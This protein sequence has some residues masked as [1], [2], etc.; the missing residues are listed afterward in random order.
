MPRAVKVTL[1]C[2]AFLV[3][4]PALA[5]AQEGQ[6]AGTVRDSSGG[7]M[8][9][10]LVEVA[11]PALIQKVRSTTSDA[12]GQYRLTNLPV[13]T[14]S[15]AFTLEGFTKQQRS[16]VQLTTGFT[17]SINATLTVGA[18]AETVTVVSETP[19]VDVQSARQV[20]PSPAPTFASCRHRAR[21]AAC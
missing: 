10:V 12:S 9:G 14:Y 17:A 7:V 18:L 11:S 13:G 19:T 5:S 2:A 6:I 20:G 4:L 8:P 15:V 1:A 21:C 16:D 3:W